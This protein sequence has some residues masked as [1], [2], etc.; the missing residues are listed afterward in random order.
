MSHDGMTLIYI[1]GGIAIAIPV[2]L[3]IFLLL[4]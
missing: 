2:V 3:L 4:M 1:V